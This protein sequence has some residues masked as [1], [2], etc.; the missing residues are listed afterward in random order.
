[1]SNQIYS[2]ASEISA[3]AA[4]NAAMAQLVVRLEAGESLQI[5][6]LDIVREPTYWLATLRVMRVAVAPDGRAQRKESKR[7]LIVAA[8]SGGQKVAPPVKPAPVEVQSPAVEV[9]FDEAADP[10]LPPASPVPP[11]SAENNPA[12]E[13]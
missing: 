10:V 8:P 6:P 3:A 4:I 11:V 12:P 9:D 13:G 7:K 2:G 1:M 5:V